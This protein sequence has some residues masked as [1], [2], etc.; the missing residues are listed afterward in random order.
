MITAE[1]AR[2]L[3]KISNVDPAV[4]RILKAIEEKAIAGCT[5]LKTGWEYDM[6]RDIWISGGYSKTKAYELACKKLKDLGFKIEFYYSDAS[7]FVDMY[8]IISWE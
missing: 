8:T 3:A 5:K 7:Q 1:K 2:E 6:D 4:D